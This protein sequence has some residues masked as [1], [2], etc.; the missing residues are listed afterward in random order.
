MT[1]QE[2]RGFSAQDAMEYL[3]GISRNGLQQLIKDK[4]LRSYRIGSRRYFLREELDAF[5]ERQI[6][7]VSL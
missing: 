3:G 1:Q 4:V 7:K 5:I 2:K 6:E